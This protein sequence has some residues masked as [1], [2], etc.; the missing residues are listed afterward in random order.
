[1]LRAVVMI[2]T[3]VNA[4]GIVAGGVAGLALRRPLAPSTQ[5]FFKVA[6]GVFTVWVGLRLAVTSLHGSIWQILQQLLVGVLALMLGRVLGHFLR[7]QKGLN[8]LGRI[9]SQKLALATPGRRPPPGE[10]FLAASVL[11]C[12]AP[13]AVLGPIPDGLAGDF[14]PLLLKAVMDGLV[15][16]ALVPNF[17]WSVILGVVPMAA[18]QVTL[19]S[20]AQWCEPTLRTYSLFDSVNLVCGLLIFCVALIIFAIRRVEVGNYLPALVLAPWL[21]WL[22]R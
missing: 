16:L 20:A 14:Q 6:L 13:L 17:G 12:A 1:M 7:L 19:T 10:G 3:I 9:A 4:A 22:W 2:G 11:Y 5:Q 8:H 21:A 15:A 18:L